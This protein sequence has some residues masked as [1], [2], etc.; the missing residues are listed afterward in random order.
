MT[1]VRRDV[2]LAV[3]V[4]DHDHGTRGASRWSID[5]AGSRFPLEM[6]S[7]FCVVIVAAEGRSIAW[8]V[9]AVERISAAART[10]E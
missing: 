3:A 6:N 2:R 8:D 7:N 9:Y 4:N 10:T 5:K 1:C